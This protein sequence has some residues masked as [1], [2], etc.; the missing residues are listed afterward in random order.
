MKQQH[1]FVRC[2]QISRY[3]EM[4]SN[5]KPQTD[6]QSKTYIYIYKVTKKNMFT[7]TNVQ[8]TFIIRVFKLLYTNECKVDSISVS[9]YT[10]LTGRE[11]R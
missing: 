1:E 6:A 9:Y 4:S 5:L 8:I 11:Q 2:F 3:L 10:N 7:K